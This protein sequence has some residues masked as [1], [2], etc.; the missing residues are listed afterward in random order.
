[1]RIAK[2]SKVNG[3]KYDILDFN[4]DNNYNCENFTGFKLKKGDRVIIEEL[5]DDE[6]L[7]IL[8]STVILGVAGKNIDCNRLKS[9]VEKIEED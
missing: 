5:T 8:A 1:M 2:V 3:N 7:D 9:A 4:G 6:E